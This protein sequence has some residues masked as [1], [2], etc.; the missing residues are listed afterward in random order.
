MFVGLLKVEHNKQSGFTLIELLVVIAIIGLLASIVFVS[1]NSARNKARYEK[2]HSEIVQFV[3]AAVV[4][5][6][7]A[8]RV[9]G[10]ITGSYCSGCQ[11]PG[12]SGSGDI[13]NISDTS[14]CAVQWYNDLVAIQA[15]SNVSGLTAMRRDPWGS[16]YV[17]DENELEGGACNHDSIG[18]AGP[19]G[20]IG[21]ADDI[22]YSGG[23]PFAI[24]K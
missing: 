19:D 10:Q 7:E 15:A 20:D 3:K 18:S 14:S 9:L 5:Q 2:V 17:L 12:W 6:G 4:A 22:W 8:N 13:R 21:T 23:I 24:C 1:L 11:C 16:P